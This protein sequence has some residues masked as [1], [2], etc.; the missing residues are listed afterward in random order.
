VTVGSGA[1]TA[2]FEEFG[3]MES[4]LALFG[5][6]SVPDVVVSA[7]IEVFAVVEGAIAWR[8]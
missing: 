8:E 5:Y 3:S 7:C 4:V 6:S 1:E 2:L